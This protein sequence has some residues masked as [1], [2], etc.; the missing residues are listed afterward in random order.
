MPVVSSA[1]FTMILGERKRGVL[2]EAVDKE[3]RQEKEEEEEEVF[4]C[5]FFHYSFLDLL[6]FISSFNA[7]RACVCVRV[8]AL[9]C[10]IVGRNRRCMTKQTSSS[11]S[12]SSSSSRLVVTWGISSIIVSCYHHHHH[13]HHHHNAITIITTGNSRLLACTLCMHVCVFTIA[14][15]FSLELKNNSSGFVCCSL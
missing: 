10:V 12:S 6:I 13:H 4:V 8:C 3:E 15:T 1:A 11:S 9:V 2:E 5:V 14:I 7:A